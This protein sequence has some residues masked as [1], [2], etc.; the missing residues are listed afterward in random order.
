MSDNPFIRT[1]VSSRKTLR[2][3]SFFSLCEGL[4]RKKLLA[5]FGELEQFRRESRNL[6]EKV[7]ATIFL[8]A[9]YRFILQESKDTFGYGHITSPC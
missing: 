4:P 8:H 3:E 7:R 2:N 9:A 6:Y 5:Y 1:I